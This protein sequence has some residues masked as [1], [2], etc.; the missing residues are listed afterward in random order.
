MLHDAGLGESVGYPLTC[1]YTEGR[2]PAVP[3]EVPTTRTSLKI[4]SQVPKTSKA[5]K[6]IG[7]GLLDWGSESKNESD[8]WSLF[9]KAGHSFKVKAS[10][11]R[12][13]TNPE[14]LKTWQN[15]KIENRNWHM[16]NIYSNLKLIL[17]KYPW[18]RLRRRP[19]GAAA[20]WAGAIFK[21][22]LK[23]EYIFTYFEHMP[24]YVFKL[25]TLSGFHT[26]RICMGDASYYPT[27][28]AKQMQHI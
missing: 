10:N 17:Q 21:M 20:P 28:S 12:P 6:L 23:I 8:R 15:G 11:L 2:K 9:V 5:L 13:P 1:R 3:V 7:S 16:L 25:A 24:N 4:L 27:S 19:Q 18:R 22:S 14:T 26:F